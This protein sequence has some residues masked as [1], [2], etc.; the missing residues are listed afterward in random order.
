MVRIG[1]GDVE[2]AFRHRAH[3]IDASARRVHFFAEHAIRGTGG[4]ADAAVD[5]RANGIECGGGRGGAFLG[6]GGGCGGGGV[7]PAEGTSFFF[8]GG[9]AA[10]P[11]PGGGGR[12][13]CPLPPPSP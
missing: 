2:T 12:G 8:C 9:R 5:A 10:G 7:P 1:F 4:E 11:P 6:G 3:Q 13:G